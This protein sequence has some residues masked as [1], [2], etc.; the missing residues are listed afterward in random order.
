MPPRHGV[1]EPTGGSPPRAPGSVR[2]TV[3]TDMLRPD[4]IRGR[5][6][7]VGRGRD[8]RTGPDGSPVELGRASFEAVVDFTGGWQL[9]ELSTD[10]GHPSLQRLAGT[11]VG[12][13]FRARVL[14]AEPGLGSLLHQLLDDVPVT[15]LVSGHA[16]AAAVA[17]EPRQRL[18]LAG[19]P[20][21]GRDMCA[22]FA[23]GGTIMADVDALGR[24]PV[25]TGPAAPSLLNADPHA[26][27]GVPP[28]PPHA[29][30]RSRRIDVRPGPVS[31]VDVLYRDSYVRPDGLETVIHEYTVAMEIENGAR[32]TFTGTS[33]CT[34]LNDTLRALEDVP[35]LLES[36]RG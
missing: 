23:D 28:L 27:H 20:T 31:T 7:L 32:E 9:L 35:I 24:A 12:A 34:H 4:G 33:T 5:L 3:T 30:R 36:A 8:L 18:G 19:R 11:S 6:E 17:A 2:R 16:Y 22:G 10:P 14:D 13:G 26:W 21:F 25:V 15:T 1:H 29:M